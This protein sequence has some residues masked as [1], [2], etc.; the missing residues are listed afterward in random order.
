MVYLIV[1]HAL[2]FITFFI[3]G[4]YHSTWKSAIIAL[5]LLAIGTVFIKNPL[6]YYLFFV[7][8]Y[9]ILTSEP[10]KKKLNTVITSFLWLAVFATFIVRCVMYQAYL[11]SIVSFALILV[12]PLVVEVLIK[13]KKMQLSKRR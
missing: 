3:F 2:L 5:V 7:V 12:I 1:I 4:H 9:F 6:F 11:Y 8:A 13:G 10:P